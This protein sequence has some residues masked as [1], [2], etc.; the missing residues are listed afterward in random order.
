VT[1]GEIL[2][3]LNYDSFAYEE[4]SQYPGFLIAKLSSEEIQAAE[5]EARSCL[6]AAAEQIALPSGWPATYPLELTYPHLLK[7]LKQLA[8]Q[9]Q[10]ATIY[11][12][13]T[14][15]PS[16]HAEDVEAWFFDY[17]TGAKFNDYGLSETTE[18]G[19][20]LGGFYV[21]G[22]HPT[23][24]YKVIHNYQ[25]PAQWRAF[26]TPLMRIVGAY[27]LIFEWNAHIDWEKRR[28]RT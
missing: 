10:T 17:R 18:Q 22:T 1:K 11:Y 27:H 25:G 21:R 4:I 6:G 9:M 15:H 19:Q 16:S 8:Q 24:A 23:T 20:W 28:I 26:D 2:K 13:L 12:R 3:G 5:T 14:T 7:Y